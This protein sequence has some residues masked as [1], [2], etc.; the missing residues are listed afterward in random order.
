MMFF[1]IILVI[2]IALILISIANTLLFIALKLVTKENYK[3]H[4]LIIPSF[5]SL[6]LWSL[7]YIVAIEIISSITGTTLF[8]SISGSLF[9]TSN[10]SKFL[11]SL[12]LPMFVLLTITLFLQSI[13][14]LTVNVDYSIPFNKF[15]YFVKQKFKAITKRHEYSDAICH[16]TKTDITQ[17]EEKYKLEFINSFVCSLFIFSLIFFLN[18]LFF[19]IGTLIAAKLI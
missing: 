2:F 18:I 12:I 7:A 1:T 17:I 3:E 14:L 5:I 19:W 11:P 10:F 9:N 15:R 8:D 6:V 16:E 4:Y 13:V